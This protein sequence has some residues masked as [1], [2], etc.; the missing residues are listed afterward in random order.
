MVDTRFDIDCTKQTNHWVVEFNIVYRFPSDPHNTGKTMGIKIL[1][2]EFQDWLK[3]VCIYSGR[4]T[5]E[6][7]GRKC[8]LWDSQNFIDIIDFFNFDHCYIL[9]NP[10]VAPCHIAAILITLSTHYDMFES[11]LRHPSHTHTHF[12]VPFHFLF[13]ALHKFPIPLFYS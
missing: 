4:A 7:G 6:S 8:T 1:K 3:I 9:M 13:F 12:P 11:T 10:G 5:W 2:W